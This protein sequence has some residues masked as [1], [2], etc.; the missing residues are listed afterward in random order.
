M[1]EMFH[2]HI[3][4]IQHLSSMPKNIPTSNFRTL[5]KLFY[6]IDLLSTKN[7]TKRNILGNHFTITRCILLVSV[8]EY[9]SKDILNTDQ[10]LDSMLVEGNYEVDEDMDDMKKVIVYLNMFNDCSCF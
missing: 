9:F 5:T 1:K 10:R 6:D 7:K 8:F 4:H 3:K 2:T